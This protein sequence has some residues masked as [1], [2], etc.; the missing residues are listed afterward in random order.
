M[1]KILEIEKNFNQTSL[2]LPD[3]AS[4]RHPTVLNRNPATKS[5]PIVP[6]GGPNSAILDNMD[7]SS[8]LP[9]AGALLVYRIK[10]PSTESVGLAAIREFWGLS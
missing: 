1:E 6:C 5:P 8:K 7:Q 3:M 9:K 10:G 2:D 4:N